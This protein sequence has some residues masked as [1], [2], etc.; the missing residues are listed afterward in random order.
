MND[1]PVINKSPIHPAFEEKYCTPELP[2]PNK[3]V[4]MQ[5]AVTVRLFIPHKTLVQPTSLIDLGS[6][7]S[8]DCQ[9][10]AK[11]TGYIIKYGPDTGAPPI[12]DP[13]TKKSVRPLYTS[14]IPGMQPGRKVSFVDSAGVMRQKIG[15]HENYCW[16][17]TI[18]FRDI[19]EI[20]PVVGYAREDNLIEEFEE[21][22]CIGLDSGAKNNAVVH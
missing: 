15:E 19:L 3:A 6:S 11:V 8:T 1:S 4:L 20:Y 22:I 2:A 18:Q 10:S 13:L 7:R 9:N 16:V 17:S 12:F 5:D 21:P 14:E